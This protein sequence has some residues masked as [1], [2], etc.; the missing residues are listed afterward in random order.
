MNWKGIV[1][2]LLVAV[3]ITACGG[4]QSVEYSSNT[5][6]ICKDGTIQD[7]SID[8]FSSGN[9]DMGKL[10]QF[11]KDEIE[12][13]NASSGDGSITVEDLNTNNKHVRLTLN[14]RS[15]ED[16]N[17]FNDKDYSIKSF[18]G[19][20]LTGSLTSASKHT[21]VSVS[22]IQDKDYQVVQVT[23]AVNLAFQGKVFYYSSNVTEKNGI[24]TSSGDG[25]ATIIYK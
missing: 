14:Y 25:V 2:A 5:M 13:Y 17:Q 7:L 1:A 24:Y 16:F 4:Q 20:N 23:D 15:M 6:T 18:A 21:S 19:S 10:E 9:Y 22:E 8:D 11:V 12:R 3:M